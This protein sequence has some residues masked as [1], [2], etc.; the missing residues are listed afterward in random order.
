MN[1]DMVRLLALEEIE[2]KLNELETYFE[3][4]SNHPQPRRS[5]HLTQQK[6]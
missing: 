1:N 4:S 6:S 2:Q 5:G 3:L